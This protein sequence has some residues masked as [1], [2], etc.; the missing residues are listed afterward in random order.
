MVK[1]IL[2]L[3]CV[4]LSLVGM[5]AQ[6]FQQQWTPL[7][8]N[9]QVKHG[10]LRNGLTYYILHNEEP[11]ERA[12]FYIA[13]KVGSSLETPEQLGLAHFLEHMAFNGT[14]HYPGKTMLNYL[15]EKGI[16][17]GAD[18]NAYTAFDQTVYN[19]NNVPTT[20]KALM[21]SVLLILHDWSGSILLEES[22]INAERGVIQEEWRTRNN[23]ETR[24]F[25]SIL[26]QIFQEYQ[27]QQMPIGKMEIV[28]NFDPEV[29]RAYYKKWYRPD[30][31]GIVIVGD[32]DA[33]EME[34]K[35]IE[36]FSPIVMPDNATERVYPSISNNKEP[37]YATF[38]DPE[39]QNAQAT[40][41]F[42]YDKIPTEFRN[43]LE[44]YLQENV[45][46]QIMSQMITIRLNEYGMKPE[47]KYAQAGC[48]FSDFYVAKT[49]GAFN[50]VVIGKDNIDEATQDALAVVTRAC[51]TGFTDGELS[52]AK[53]MMISMYEKAFNERNKTNN[54]DRAQEL[55]NT[56][57]D[58][59]ATP[60]IEV[61]FELI[62][63]ILP[64]LPVQ[65]FNEFAATLL[66]PENQVMVVSQPKT[67]TSVLPSKEDYVGHVENILN[68]EY[69]AVKDEALT[70]PLID[71][72]R[73]PGKVK[74]A[75]ANEELGT[76]EMT[77]SN[78]AK[79]IVKPTDFAS[80]EI[81]LTAYRE[82]GKRSYPVSQAANLKLIGSAFDFSTLGNYNV[83][84]M[85]RFLAGKKVSLGFDVAN[86]TTLFN[87]KTTVKDLET[88]LSL[89]YASFTAVGSDE[90][91]YNAQ[92]AAVRP[93]IAN[94][95]KN[96]AKIF[97]D[98]RIA[99]TYNNNPMMTN[100]NVATLDEASYPEMLNMIKEA[101]KNAADYTFIFTGNV[102]AETL[103]PMLEKYIAS[104]P[105]K[106]ASK[107]NTITTLNQVQGQ[108][109]D[110][111]KQ[112]METP[113]TT[114]FDI[115]SDT[116]LAY[117]IENIV[118]LD[119]LGDILGNIYTNTLREEEGGTY[120]ADVVGIMNPNTG[121][122]NILY[123]FQTNKDQQASLI[124]RADKELMNLLANGAN[125]ED[126]NKV[127]EA[128]L[129]QFEINSRKNSYWD[130][131]LM[132]YARGWNTISNHRAAIENLTLEDF[133]AFMKTL[134]NGKN[135][136]Q[137]IM[138]GVAK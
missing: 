58:N 6:E 10:V 102:D 54:D 62:K 68:A 130:N 113:G 111:W 24:M 28:M 96:P 26:P 100:M 75:V 31:Q 87:G 73:K 49:K 12:N 131:N 134:Y 122:W 94:A 53:D 93:S 106:K 59:D 32:F 29:L 51:K 3:A 16:R 79:V 115:Y 108:V 13:Q 105:G 17:F 119:I 70:K 132:T 36:M 125:A 47:C 86:Y 22:E 64:M 85:Q 83:I 56:F 1:R 21:D 50:V 27:Y 135:R 67:E 41:S 76:T 43:T 92:I 63:Q 35:V 18:I 69:E 14:S 89:I 104:L 45:L 80:D 133:N 90:E 52:R 19:I 44:A 121:T 15:Q 11:K 34:K 114:V 60:G 42:K 116:N 97:Q 65:Q 40:I 23:A 82:G 138:E 107:V 137:V 8:L 48:Y 66:T 112:P 74:S 7:P 99:V 91:T 118:K 98:K 57:L 30:Q 2:T 126:F 95:D 81:I 117:T 110:E 129:K 33:A 128:A 84:D 109:I 37:I 78:G 39:L 72:M 71:K 5:R 120:G 136:I 103:R 124:A 25:T 20:D 88:L 46:Q 77:L 4:L 55:I 123:S 61:E 9:S 101:T 127:R 38:T